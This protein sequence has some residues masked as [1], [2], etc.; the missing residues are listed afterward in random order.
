MESSKAGCFFPFFNGKLSC[1]RGL[2]A[3]SDDSR[4]V[5]TRDTDHANLLNDYFTS[6]CTGDNGINP[7]FQ[8]AVPQE[9]QLDTFIFTPKTFLPLH[10]ETYA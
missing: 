7:P 3:L 5:I 6:V 9:T 10:T 8:R 1:K 2:G 4:N